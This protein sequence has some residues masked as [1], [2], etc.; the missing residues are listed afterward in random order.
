MVIDYNK[1]WSSHNLKVAC[2][3]IEFNRP[4]VARAV[5]QTPLL[6]ESFSHGLWKYVQT[7]RA[8]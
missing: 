3:K 1:A 5:L 2:Y 6:L 8:R 7:V 4:G